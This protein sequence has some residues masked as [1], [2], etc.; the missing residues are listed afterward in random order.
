MTQVSPLP[1]LEWWH[2][3][4]STRHVHEADDRIDARTVAA[5]ES[6]GA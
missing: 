4:V 5:S 2:G 3:G 1:P 6:R